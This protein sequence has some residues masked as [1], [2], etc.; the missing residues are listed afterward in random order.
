MIIKETE[1]KLYEDQLGFKL[2]ELKIQPINELWRIKETENKIKRINDNEWIFLRFDS[3][4]THLIKPESEASEGKDI[5]EGFKKACDY[6]QRFAQQRCDSIKKYFEED[7]ATNIVSSYKFMNDQTKTTSSFLSGESGFTKTLCTIADFM[8]YAKFDNIEQEKEHNELKLERI[9][10]EKK[11]KKARKE[12]DERRLAEIKDGLKQTPYNRRTNELN[13]HPKHMSF[14]SVERLLAEEGGVIETKNK[15]NYTRVDKYLQNGEFL[16]GENEFWERISPKEKHEIP[17]Y[18]GDIVPFKMIGRSIIQQ[19]NKEIAHFKSLPFEPNRAKVISNLKS[20]MRFSLDSLRKV[21]HFDPTMDISETIPVDSWNHMSE[22]NPEFYQAVLFSYYDLNKKYAN[23][24]STTMWCVLKDFE[25]LLHKTEWSI[26][27]AVIIEYI[28]ETG[29][30]EHKAIQEE[31][32][33]VLNYDIS[34]STLSDW[35][36]K[37]IPNKIHHAFEQRLEDWIWIY[38]RKG[39]YKTCSCCHKT[40]LSVDNRYFAIDKKGKLGLASKCKACTN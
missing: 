30:T 31:L 18:K 7:K 25:N 26:Q 29:N 24:P 20:E 23:K 16:E 2:E 10:L 5:W 6:S 37:N 3:I 8:L 35:L 28:L 32:R 11:R 36:N 9:R 19:F 12:A 1:L 34:T 33:E 15:V 39:K 27:E 13:N 14:T 4:H 17:F 21:I 40:K 22:R 38:R